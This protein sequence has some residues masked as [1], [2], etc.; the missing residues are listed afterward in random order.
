[1]IAVLVSLLALGP[2]V[3]S[4]QRGPAPEGT[5]I[6]SIDVSGFDRARLSPGLRHDVHAL[7]GT[8]LKQA[9]LDELAARI[10]GE[11]PKYKASVRAVLDTD[12][13]VVTAGDSSCLM[14][15]GGG[16]S[17]LDAG[18]RAVHLAEILASTA[19]AEVG[20]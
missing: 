7:E 1:M 3:P 5:I 12:A 13:E 17:R 4:D 9:R 16:L 2:Q 11:R 8:P 10:E 19:D 18:V 15:I 6:S 20:S 14:H